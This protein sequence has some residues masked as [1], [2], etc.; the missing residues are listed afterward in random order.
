M[1]AAFRNLYIHIPFCRRKCGYCAFFSEPG[2]SRTRQ[3]R[4]LAVL[5][6]H[7]KACAP[8]LRRVHT[9]YFGGGTPSVL[10]PDLLEK[11]FET[12]SACAHL[13]PDAEITMEANP[14]SVTEDV[15]RAAAG[16]VNRVSM[17]VQSFSPRLLASVER[18][19]PESGAV[20]RALDLWRKNGVSNIGFDLISALPGQTAADLED[21]LEKAVSA[22]IRHLS[23]Y[24]LMVEDGT[25]LASGG[26][27]PDPDLAA[28]MWELTGDVLSAHGMP[29]Y[30]ISNYAAPDFEAR[31]NQNVW[32][33]ETYLGLGPAASGFD[34]QDRFTNVSSLDRWCAGTPPERDV[35]PRPR[36]LRE[37][38]LMGLRTVRGWA[39]DEFLRATGEPCAFPELEALT[40]EGL[41]ETKD[42]AI[43]ATP[44]GLA[45]WNEI[46]LR[47]L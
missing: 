13:E 30:E 7:L 33:G 12:V 39:G 23:V 8:A 40:A 41:L 1:T 15:C 44:R 22:G 2:A 29:R 20:F 10:A 3:E 37:I 43:R 5:S 47:L 6:D 36:R 46:A 38:F 26:F 14:D 34:G 27:R 35:I 18:H 28:E 16:F 24:S 25:P 31:H 9:V 17:G 21:D 42:G 11:L 32:H 4:Y 19:A 45:F